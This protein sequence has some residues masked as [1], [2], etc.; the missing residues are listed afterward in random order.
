MRYDVYHDRWQYLPELLGIMGMCSVCGF[1]NSSYLYVFTDNFDIFYRL[2]TKQI[3][4][5]LN[6]LQMYQA[7]PIRWEIV[8][9]KE[10]SYFGFAMGTFMLDQD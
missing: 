5:H 1:N 4:E 7:K 10:R 9:V 3:P 2:D 6:A 8:Q